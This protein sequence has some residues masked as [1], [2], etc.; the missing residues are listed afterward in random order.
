MFPQP[1]GM[2]E[3]L[4]SKLPGFVLRSQI[5]Q[6]EQSHFVNVFAPGD[7]KEGE[8]LPVMVSDTLAIYLRNCARWNAD[9]ITISC[10]T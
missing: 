7:L 4:L 8:K 10:E 2:T 3:Q 1:Q 6:C 9:E 5:K